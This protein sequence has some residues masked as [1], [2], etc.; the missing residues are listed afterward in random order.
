MEYLTRCEFNEVLVEAGSKLVGSLLGAGLVDEVILYIAPSF[1]GDEGRGIAELPEIARLSDR[2]QAEF[3]EVERIG[4][5]LKITI[6]L[7]RS[8]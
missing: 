7:D 5:D 8:G 2:I 4:E 1:I 6:E 3:T